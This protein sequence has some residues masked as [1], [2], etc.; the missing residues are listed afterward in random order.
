MKYSFKTRP[1]GPSWDLGLEPGRVEKKQ[2][3]EK[4]GMTRRVDPARPGQ[5]PVCNP[6][7]FVF[8]F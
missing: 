4:P 5:K 1:G 3:K 6:L 2:G 7:T 8:F